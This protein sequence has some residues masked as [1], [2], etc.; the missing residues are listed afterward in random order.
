MAG[1]RF[2]RG[3]NR[4]ARRQTTWLDVPVQ[5]STLSAASQLILSLTAEELAKRPFTVIRTRLTVSVQSDQ[6]AGSETGISAIGLCVV[7]D[8][9]L[10]IGVTAVPTPITDL[11]SDLWLMH[12]PLISAFLFATA[13][14][15]EEPNDRIYEIDSKAMRKVNNDQDLVMVTENSAVGGGAIITVLGRILIK[16]Y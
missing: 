12:Q 11:A 2:V 16:E 5:V 15:F 13:A 10:A 6:S 7:S 9:A 8:Q 4:G 14:G 1:K 3:V